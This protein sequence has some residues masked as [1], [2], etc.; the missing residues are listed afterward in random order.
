MNYQYYPSLDEPISQ[1]LQSLAKHGPIVKKRDHYTY[2][3][4]DDRYVHDVYP[5]I[6]TA[7]RLKPNYFC[8]QSEFIG[9]HVSLL[10]PKEL[11]TSNVLLTKHALKFD[12]KGLFSANILNKRYFALQVESTEITALRHQNGLADLL[13]FKGYPIFPHIT[14]AVQMLE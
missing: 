2:I 12:I 4:I 11:L 13:Q 9:A 5:L 10:Y 3:D 1:V 6:E 7:E 8:K 14:V